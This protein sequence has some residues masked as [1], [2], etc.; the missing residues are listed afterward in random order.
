MPGNKD[1]SI[2]GLSVRIGNVFG[3]VV[4]ELFRIGSGGFKEGFSRKD[5]KAQR[6]RSAERVI[7]FETYRLYRSIYFINHKKPKQ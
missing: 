3:A 2:L 1:R 4:S 5:A 7:F 6:G